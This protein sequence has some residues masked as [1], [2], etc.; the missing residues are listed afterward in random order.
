[1]Y[2][3]TQSRLYTMDCHFNIISIDLHGHTC[4][5]YAK[6]KAES[7]V[8]VLLSQKLLTSSRG[9]SVFIG[10]QWIDVVHKVVPQGWWIAL[11]VN[12]ASIRGATEWMVFIGGASSAET[13]DSVVPWT[14]PVNVITVIGEHCVSLTPIC[15]HNCLEGVMLY[16]S[17]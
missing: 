2:M 8:A 10:S 5:N 3:Y 12:V 6:G 15:D 4:L 7:L 14:D 13:N 17:K 11:T 1:M 16:T 9:G